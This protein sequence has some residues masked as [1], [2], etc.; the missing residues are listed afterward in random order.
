MG[1]RLQRLL[2]SVILLMVIAESVVGL[3]QTFDILPSVNNIFKMTGPFKNP[4]PFG[5][6]VA[7]GLALVIV[8]LDRGRVEKANGFLLNKII[9]LLALAMGVIV[10]PASM[11][12]AAWLALF[13]SLLSYA[14]IEKNLWPILKKR[15]SLICILL[16]GVLILS[17]ATFT[18]KR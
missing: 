18:I 5:G 1:D 11:S 4:G 14:F 17:F 8:L 9:S 16:V 12:R 13:V 7:V 2:I 15:P 10:L 6:F 3:L